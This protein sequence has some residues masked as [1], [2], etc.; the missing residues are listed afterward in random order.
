MPVSYPE[1]NE[2]QG[3]IKTLLAQKGEP[4]SIGRVIR[5]DARRKLV[6]VSGFGQEPIPMMSFNGD[7]NIYDE[8][9]EFQIMDVRYTAGATYYP[10]AAA[11]DIDVECVGGGGGGGGTGNIPGYG[12]GGGGSGGWTT[13]RISAPFPAAGYAVTIGNG[14][15]GGSGGGVAGSDGGNTKFV[16][17]SGANAANMQGGGGN[18]ATGTGTAGTGGTATG[19]DFNIPGRDGSPGQYRMD[20]ADNT[21]QDPGGGGTGGSSP[22]GGGGGGGFQVV[23]RA[24]TGYGSGGGGGGKATGSN[25]GGGAGS[26]GIVLV[27]EYRQIPVVRKK[28][29]TATP[30]VPEVGEYV[31]VAHHLGSRELPKC[32]G[33]LQSVGFAGYDPGLE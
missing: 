31:L 17:G 21:Y 6:W 1:W 26:A 24:A 16:G 13:K 27:K 2:I 23:G 32:L 9:R 15:A 19:G 11:R 10:H 12:G 20:H 28:F 33:T 7:I 25:P 3:K 5:R 22:Y 29:T 18:G 8:Y 4:F 30:R 14:G